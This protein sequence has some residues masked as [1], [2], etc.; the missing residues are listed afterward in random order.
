MTALESKVMG[1]QVVGGK[2]SV[3]PTGRAEAA[4]GVANEGS[5]ANGDM[6]LAMSRKS[7]SRSEV[8]RV[9]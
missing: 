9:I 3:S 6:M 2:I 7:E 8:L 5:I 4:A 1:S